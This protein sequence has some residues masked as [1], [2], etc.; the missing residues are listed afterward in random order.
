MSI[1]DNHKAEFVKAVEHFHS[2]ITG[3]KTGRANPAILDSVRVEAYGVFNPIN[4]VGSV[5]V[6]DARSLVIT[7]WDKSI[8]KDIEK[9]II[10][11]GLNLNP[12][13][14]GDKIRINMPALTEESR[15]EIVKHLNQ[16]TEEA[17][18]ALRLIRD[19]VKEEVIVA[20]KNKDFGEDEK[21]GLLEALDKVVAKHNEEIKELSEKK[22]A[23]IMTV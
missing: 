12:I 19:K 3:L 11:S 6:P 17:K 15:K 14:D 9:A 21:F 10:E 23:E 2:E 16:K 4:A 5:G 13:N 1:I 22:E 8:V 7:P 18:I 20:E